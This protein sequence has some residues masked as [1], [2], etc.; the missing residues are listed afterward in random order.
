M[1]NYDYHSLF[2]YNILTPLQ[3]LIGSDG[4]QLTTI[5]RQK[6]VPEFRIAYPA[7]GRY[8][9][10][11]QRDQ[12][13][14]DRE[15]LVIGRKSYDQPWVV[16]LSVSRHKDATIVYKKALRHIFKGDIA[17]ARREL[18]G[19]L[20]KFYEVSLGESS[21]YIQAEFGSDPNSQDWVPLNAFINSTK[22]QAIQS[23]QPSIRTMD[24]SEYYLQTQQEDGPVI[25]WRIR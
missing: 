5:T 16:V 19:L 14:K 6:E 11:Y 7:R 3:N 23:L 10:Q 15:R 12:F 9:H 2:Y 18:V 8:P 25:G 17:V 1:K 21:V 13:L 4:H 20:E 24:I 22:K